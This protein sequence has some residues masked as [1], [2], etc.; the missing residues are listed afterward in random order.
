M[1]KI[2]VVAPRLGIQECAMRVVQ[3]ESFPHCDPILFCVAHGSDVD[4]AA[5]KVKQEKVD[6]IIARGQQAALMR[7]KTPVPVVDILLTGQEMGIMVTRAREMLNKNK[8]Q[9]AVIGLCN[10]FSDIS[11]FDKLFS[12]ELKEYLVNDV[13]DLESAAQLAAQEGV[14]IILGGDL[15]CKYARK[16]GIP[17][18]FVESGYEGLFT[19]LRQADLIAQIND[20]ERE[21]IA[22]IRVLLD[23][24]FNGIIR[25]DTN[26]RVVS[27]NHIAETML[28]L[29]PNTSQSFTI[30]QL[31]PRLSEEDLNAV[32]L[33][34]RELYSRIVAVGSRTF[35]VNL[36][37][38]LVN[39]KVDG[40]ILSFQESG[41]LTRMES[42]MRQAL[43]SQGKVVPFRFKEFDYAHSSTM[44]K[45]IAAAQMYAGSDAPILISGE[46]G[47]ETTQIAQAIHNESGRSGYPFITFPCGCVDE[48][49]CS[50]D[51]F[52]H[53]ERD[54]N[55]SHGLLGEAEGGTLLLEDIEKLNID[56]QR[57]LLRYLQTGASISCGTYNP[58]RLNVRII[59]ACSCDL[60]QMVESN[61]FMPSLYYAL[62]VLSLKI[63]PLNNREE[64][65][66]AL[67]EKYLQ[68]YGYRYHRYV[69]LTQDAQKVM[70]KYPW[71]GNLPQLRAFC[72]RMVFT[73]PHR[74][75]NAAYIEKLLAQAYPL[76]IKN[77]PKKCV[78]LN[79]PESVIISRLI[80]KYNGDRLKIA[81]EMSIS[82]TTLWRKMKAL[83]LLDVDVKDVFD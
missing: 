45:A 53:T 83:G 78:A 82:K 49:T 3:Q 33:E 50:A 9:I 65:I 38:V 63:P 59:A 11:E 18:L 74:S 29:Q 25:L 34:G 43:Y 69:T 27:I 2:M 22:Q 67:I 46:A 21:N 80:E 30:Q 61:L 6:V 71:A 72:E 79:T 70:C 26:W 14:D 20:R 10:M 44:K 51:L 81:N 56:S 5:Q 68:E 47:T 39:G 15:G 54:D 41:A 40:T 66:L 28:K 24:S 23:Y 77:S 32:L 12:V 35:L 17:S 73:S 8:P 60:A 52:G 4:D 76:I 7:K 42:S 57:R 31:M 37:P 55:K 36:A 62:A 16:N 19:A 13:M 58:Q 1:A 75:V 64:D 48:E